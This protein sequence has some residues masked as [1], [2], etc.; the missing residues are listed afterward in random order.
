MATTSAAE[1]VSRRDLLCGVIAGLSAVALGAVTIPSLPRI[2]RELSQDL[3]GWAYMSPRSVQAY[4]AALAQPV[5]L[6]SLACYCGCARLQTPHASLL[7]CFVRPNGAFEPHA[8]GC[9]V[10]Q[11][12]AIDARRLAAQ[13][14]PADQIRREID[15]RYG[16]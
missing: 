7:E 8:S 10:C 12:E 11:D 14:L 6:A 4:R 15:A 1:R 3:P 5:L 2:A 9:A 13:S 16:G